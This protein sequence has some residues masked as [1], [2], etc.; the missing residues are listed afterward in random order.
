MYI[1]IKACIFSVSFSAIGLYKLNMIAC[2]T[3]N[4]A[5][6]NKESILLN[7]PLTPKYV[8]PNSFINTVLVTKF[9]I[10]NKICPTNPEYMFFNEFFLFA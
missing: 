9:V 5:N 4:S 8:D 2:P 6:D 7:K 10:N 3:P 1:D